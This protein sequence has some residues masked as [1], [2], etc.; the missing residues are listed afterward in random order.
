MLWQPCDDAAARVN[1]VTPINADS[2]VFLSVSDQDLCTELAGTARRNSTAAEQSCCKDGLVEQRGLEQRQ[3]GLGLC[4]RQ[5]FLDGA[6]RET[7]AESQGFPLDKYRG[8]PRETKAESQGQG[9]ANWR[10]K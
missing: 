2:T 9:A 1:A 7:K 4:K 5:E 8:T 10:W 6:P 3:Q